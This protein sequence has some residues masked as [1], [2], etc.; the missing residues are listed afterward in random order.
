MELCAFLL[1]VLWYRDQESVCGKDEEAHIGLLL[2]LGDH[3]LRKIGMQKRADLTSLGS[4][5]HISIMV[6][7]YV[8]TKKRQE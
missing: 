7:V 3:I 2:L 8:Y 5:V 6:L 1:L 4:Y